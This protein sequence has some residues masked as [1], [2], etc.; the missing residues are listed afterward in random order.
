MRFGKYEFGSIRV[1]GNMYMPDVVIDHGAVRKRKKRPSKIFR[2][3]Y[4]HTPLSVAEKIPWNCRRLVIGTGC[5]GAL[6][7]MDDVR[8]EAS[9][10]HIELIALPTASAIQ[11]LNRH[12]EDTNAVLHVTC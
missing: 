8:R 12:I 7:I 3:A 5:D 9:V 2:G 4:G 1:D 6:P 11:E 10:R